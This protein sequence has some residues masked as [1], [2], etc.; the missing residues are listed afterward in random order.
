MSGIHVERDVCT[1]VWTHSEEQWLLTFFEPLT[2][3]VTKKTISMN[4]IRENIEEVVHARST[5]YDKMNERKLRL[6]GTDYGNLGPL[7]FDSGV[8]FDGRLEFF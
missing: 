8:A 6:Q 5:M 2:G 1:C 4:E 3:A 7:F